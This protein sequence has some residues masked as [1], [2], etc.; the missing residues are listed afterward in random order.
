M[1]EDADEL[2]I[3]IRAH[4]FGLSE[5]KSKL[6]SHYSCLYISH[7]IGRFRSEEKMGEKTIPPNLLCQTFRSIPEPM[8][9]SDTHADAGEA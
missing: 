6:P 2:C 9:L 3:E 8:I 1:H 5:K 7:L 4:R